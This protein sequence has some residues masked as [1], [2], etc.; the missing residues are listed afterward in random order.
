V[1]RLLLELLLAPSLVAISTVAAWRWGERAGGVVSAFPAIVGPV[2]LILALAHGASFAAKAANGTLLGLASLAAF[3]LAYG[4]LA[5]RRDWRVS[6]IAGWTGAAVAGLAVGVALG[7][8]GQPAGLAAAAVSLVLAR[9][10]LPDTGLPA[11]APRGSMLARMATAALLVASLAAAA[12]ALGP[13]AGGMLAALPVLACV[14]AVFTHREQG[15]AA[16]V[17]LLGGMLAGM[18]SFVV[19]CQLIAMLTRPYGIAA[20]FAAATAAAVIVQAYSVQSTLRRQSSAPSTAVAAAA[21]SLRR[22]S[23]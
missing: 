16:A 8:A 19:F 6:L 15:G 23:S 20:A 3:T 11:P 17:G 5:H 2:L 1:T 14:L 10:A 7:G 18:V 21:G 4:R 12:G 9:L 22:Q 13:L